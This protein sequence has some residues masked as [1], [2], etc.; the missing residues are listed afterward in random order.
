LGLEPPLPPADGAERAE[1]HATDGG[2]GEPVSEQEQDVGAEANRGVV[3][4]TV[5]AEQGLALGVGESDTCHGSAL[6]RTGENSHVPTD[7]WLEPAYLSRRRTGG[8]GG[9]TARPVPTGD[10]RTPARARRTATRRPGLRLGPRRGTG[11][12]PAGRLLGRTD[13]ATPGA[14]REA[15]PEGERRREPRRGG[16]PGPGEGRRQGRRPGRGVARVPRGDR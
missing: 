12:P 9:R 3:C 11:R 16:G 5:M 13:Q 1:Q 8:R 14:G 15:Q 10:R 6:P 2:P 7:R 4:P